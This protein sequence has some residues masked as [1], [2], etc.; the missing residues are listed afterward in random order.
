MPRYFLFKNKVIMFLKMIMIVI[1]VNRCLNSNI[2]TRCP[3]IVI[4]HS[5]R[6]VSLQFYCTCADAYSKKPTIKQKFVLFYFYF[7]FALVRSL[8]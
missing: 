6:L 8:Q 5:H 1:T 2:I 3:L 4:S 7:S